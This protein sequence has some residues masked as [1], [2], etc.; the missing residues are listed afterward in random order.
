MKLIIEPVVC[1]NRCDH[2]AIT[3]VSAH[4][5][6]AGRFRQSRRPL[7]VGVTAGHSLG[8]RSR[9]A[10]SRLNSGN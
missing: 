8:M 10:A 9:V 4:E 6:P 5:L 1:G 3:T 7:A 2:I